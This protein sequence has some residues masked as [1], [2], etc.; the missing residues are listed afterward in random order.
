MGKDLNGMRTEAHRPLEEEDSSQRK[1]QV[2]RPEAGLCSIFYGNHS[3]PMA[4]AKLV[5]GRREG[6]V[7]EGQQAASYRAFVLQ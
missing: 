2:Q 6:E 1:Q 3:D 5:T 4:S 7:R